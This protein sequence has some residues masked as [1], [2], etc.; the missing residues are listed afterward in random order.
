METM[1]AI[2]AGIS[3]LLVIDFAAV[4][5]GADSRDQMVDDHQR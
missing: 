1:F 5:W 4:I 3:A 2:F